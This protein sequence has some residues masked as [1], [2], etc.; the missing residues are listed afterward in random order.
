MTVGEHGGQLHK[1]NIQRVFIDYLRYIGLKGPPGTKGPRI[2]DLRH[3]YATRTLLS[4]YRAG[5]DVERLLP[6]L[7]TYLGHTH[8][9][10]TYWYLTTCPELMSHAVERLE[11]RWE[12]S[13]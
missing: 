7:S 5:E 9:R 12:V 3:T 6:V 1:Q 11:S 10:D 8:T 2:H 4:W 13:R